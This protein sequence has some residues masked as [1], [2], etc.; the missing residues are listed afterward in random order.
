[1][2]GSKNNRTIGQEE[3]I[4]DAAIREVHPDRFATEMDAALVIQPTLVSINTLI[5]R[6]AIERF[7]PIK[8]EDIVQSI[9][10]FHHEGLLGQAIQAAASDP[11]LAALV[12]ASVQEGHPLGAQLRPKTDFIISCL[13]SHSRKKPEPMPPV[14]SQ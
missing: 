10:R 5:G 8:F 1:M 4:L 14:S 6:P 13:N 11:V 2:F 12:T 9:R 3:R 7:F